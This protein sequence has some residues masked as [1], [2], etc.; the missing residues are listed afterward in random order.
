MSSGGVGK[1]EKKE[2]KK[3]AAIP[4]DYIC[5]ITSDIMDDPVMLVDGHSYERKA[6]AEWFLKHDTSPLTNLAL[7]AKTLIPNRFLKQKIDE[8]KGQNNYLTVEKFDA[9]VLAGDTALC[10]MTV[11]DHMWKRQFLL[12]C[13]PDGAP[14]G[15]KNG[16]YDAFSTFVI[17]ANDRSA[18]KKFPEQTEEKLTACLRTILQGTG[19]DVPT[20]MPRLVRAT[21]VSWGY[22][23][24]LKALL[25]VAR[26]VHTPELLDSLDVRDMTLLHQA[27]K[28]DAS[29]ACV[30]V[31]LKWPGKS[32]VNANGSSGTPLIL[33]AQR[34]PGLRRLAVISALIHAKADVNAE[35]TTG[36][37]ALNTVNDITGMVEL[38]NYGADPSPVESKTKNPV[39][40]RC[41]LQRA[42]ELSI[43]YGDIS[44]L[45]RVHT[46]KA[47]YTFNGKTVLHYVA[48]SDNAQ[49]RGDLPTTRRVMNELFRLFG[50][51]HI[52]AQAPTGAYGD[53]TALHMAARL[54]RLNLALCLLEHGAD[55]TALD[56]KGMTPLQ[57]RTF[58]E[59]ST[60]EFRKALAEAEKKNR[61]SLIDKRIRHLADEH[62]A[63]RASV[64]AYKT[65]TNKRIK[66]L[67]DTVATLVAAAAKS[68]AAAAAPPPP[69]AAASDKEEKKRAA[70]EEEKQKPEAS[71][72]K[73]K[74]IADY[75]A[76]EE[77]RER[78]IAA[79][80]EAGQSVVVVPEEYDSTA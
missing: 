24:L 78:D 64:A 15:I 74:Q 12:Q 77:E 3:A 1:P 8:W 49:A 22:A 6:I 46:A 26:P 48:M 33:A 54:G 67:E 68:A 27:A 43:Q 7:P 16:N 39:H 21:A 25:T 57:N 4:P 62:E 65:S 71:R 11:P 58:D 20:V 23:T 59:K 13:Q 79:A 69:A 60:I 9:L 51:D 17:A 2:E 45:T 63:V 75:D 50:N 70:E 52:N 72:K 73:R 61:D 29:P 66:T 76:E 30:E 55:P 41:V 36:R 5:A 38:L 80:L 31:L 56:C 47:A 32:N 53:S 14:Y 10:K 42:V 40:Q 28:A 44:I 35:S 18:S 37:T 19:G 34:P